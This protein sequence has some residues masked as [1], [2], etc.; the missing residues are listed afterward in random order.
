MGFS[1]RFGVAAFVLWVVAL[2]DLTLW[3]VD[4]APVCVRYN[5]TLGS[6]IFNLSTKGVAVGLYWL[7]FTVTG[8]PTSHT[9]G[10][11]MGR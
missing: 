6:Y 8:D 2:T 7:G 11:V 10:F 1:R 4:S 5:E 3:A 9:V